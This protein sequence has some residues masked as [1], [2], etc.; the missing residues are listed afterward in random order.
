MTKEVNTIIGEIIRTLRES[1]ELTQQELADY[2]NV[3]RGFISEIENGKKQPSFDMLLK[4]S[5]YLNT[6]PSL[7]CAQAEKQ[8]S[9]KSELA[10]LKDR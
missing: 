1:E 2:A 9:G 4:L 5:E 7:I 6:K 3:D 10:W 8:I